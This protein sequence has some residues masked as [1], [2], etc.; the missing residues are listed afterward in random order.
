MK[1]K[2]RTSKLSPQKRAWIT[3][4]TN[5]KAKASKRMARKSAASVERAAA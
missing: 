3:R 5:E 2:S 4:R 1:T